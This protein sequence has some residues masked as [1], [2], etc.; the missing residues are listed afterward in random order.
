MGPGPPVQL[1][2]LVSQILTAII[3]PVDVGGLELTDEA[4]DDIGMVTFLPHLFLRM[5]GHERST[6]VKLK[7]V[8]EGSA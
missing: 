3:Q 4:L 8:M 7:G 6:N 5:T 2:K 1:V